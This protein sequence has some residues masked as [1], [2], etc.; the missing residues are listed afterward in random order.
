MSVPTS[1]GHYVWTY[2]DGEEWL[3]GNCGIADMVVVDAQAYD[4]A[5]FAAERLAERYPTDTFEVRD[6]M[7]QVVDTFGAERE[8]RLTAPPIVPERK[9]RA[10]GLRESFNPSL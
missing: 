9:R 1:K 6:V 7:G 8:A 2:N 3:S 4:R 10:L 5:R